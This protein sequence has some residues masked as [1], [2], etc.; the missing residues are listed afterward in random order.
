MGD[1][2][3][4]ILDLT[5]GSSFFLLSDEFLI[6]LCIR[7]SPFRYVSFLFSDVVF[8]DVVGEHDSGTLV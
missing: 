8:V 1:D 3:D 5:Y 7:L 2:Y 6:A 4:D